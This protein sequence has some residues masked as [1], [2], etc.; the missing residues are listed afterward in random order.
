MGYKLTV[1]D[2]LKIIEYRHTGKI[3]R[4]EMGNA[5]LEL[6]KLKEFTE[7]QYN[8]LADLTE[9]TMAFTIEEMEPIEEFLLSIR[10]V[11][12]EKRMAVLVND[13]HDTVISMLFEKK[14]FR[15]IGF[16][17]RTFSTRQAALNFV[18]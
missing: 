9:G 14:T 10:D 7:L 18:K 13:P 12:D 4:D 2:A 3:T 5:W 6:L 16:S 15:E 8:L 1:L 17:I 11:L